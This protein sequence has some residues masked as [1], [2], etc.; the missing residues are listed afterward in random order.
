[1]IND[2]Q[3]IFLVVCLQA[4]M[5]KKNKNESFVSQLFIK[6]K[7]KYIEREFFILNKI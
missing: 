2:D 5:N 4:Y 3:N 1:M 7:K 6:K